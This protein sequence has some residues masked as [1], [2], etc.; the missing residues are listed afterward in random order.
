[1]GFFNLYK[2]GSSAQGASSLHPDLLSLPL[3]VMSMEHVLIPKVY[4]LLPKDLASEANGA[5]EASA[6][7]LHFHSPPFLSVSDFLF[8]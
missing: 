8:V 5:S 7:L 1:M 3:H 6:K 4:F 2:D